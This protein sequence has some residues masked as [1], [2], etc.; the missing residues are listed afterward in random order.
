MIAIIG[1]MDE[2][3]AALLERMEDVQS[4]P[5]SEIPFYTGKLAGQPVIVTRSG[6][7]KVYAAMSTTILMEYFD[8]DGVI[9]IGTAGGLMENQEV[10]DVVIST[11]I[12]CHD[13][14]VP[15]WPKGFDQDKTCYAADPAYVRLISGIISAEDRAWTGPI[16]SGDSFVCREDQVERLKREFPGALCAEMEAAAIA[17][18]CQH[19]HKPFVVIR[20]LSDITLR[21][22]NGMTFEEYVVRASKRSA[23]WCEKFVTELAKQ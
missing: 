6:I 1:A 18:V 16:A 20:S 19:Y 5:I 7:A 21:E 4:R 15:G 14:D 2:E 17:Q 3:V 10:L 9:N 13:I 11:R 22:G 12:A 8:V 23:V